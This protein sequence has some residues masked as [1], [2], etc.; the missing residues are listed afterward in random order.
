QKLYGDVALGLAGP[1]EKARINQ[2]VRELEEEHKDLEITIKELE[3]RETR[4]DRGGY[5]KFYRH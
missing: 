1:G 2:E 5:G 3:I 4:L